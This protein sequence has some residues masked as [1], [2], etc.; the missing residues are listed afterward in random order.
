MTLEIDLAKGQ[1]GYRGISSCGICEKFID[2]GIDSVCIG[3][4]YHYEWVHLTCFMN[5]IKPVINKANEKR[6]FQF[7]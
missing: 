5:L 4:E 1:A 2:E 7:R 6:K 3:L